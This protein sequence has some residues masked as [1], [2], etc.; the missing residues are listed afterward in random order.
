MEGVR[1]LREEWLKREQDQLRRAQEQT[2]KDTVKEVNANMNACK[3]NL[4]KTFVQRGRFSSV[5][6]YYGACR[7]IIMGAHLESDQAFELEAKWPPGHV[8]IDRYDK[9]VI[10]S[11]LPPAFGFD[12]DPPETEE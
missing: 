8:K 1:K 9:G 4:I 11:I 2:M 5:Y 3:Q 6:A 10:A 12:P 7:H